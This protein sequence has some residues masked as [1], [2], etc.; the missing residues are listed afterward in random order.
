[1]PTSEPAPAASRVVTAVSDLGEALAGTSRL[2]AVLTRVLA[3]VRDLWQ[4]DRVLAAARPASQDGLIVERA[5]WPSTADATGLAA[6]LEH[7]APVTCRAPLTDQ[8]DSSAHELLA[9]PIL[10]TTRSIGVLAVGRDAGPFTADDQAALRAIASQA[11]IAIT[12]A[13]LLTRLAGGKRQWEQTVDAIPYAFCLVDPRGTILRANRAFANMVDCPVT[14]IPAHPWYAIMPADWRE[15][16]SLALATPD[17]DTPVELKADDRQYAATAVTMRGAE[18]GTVVLV[19]E[20]HTDKRTLQEQVVQA[21]K[22]SAI[23]QLIAGI[24]HE[25]NNPLASVV[26]FAEYLVEDRRDIP[27]HFLEPL[28][29]IH[30]EAERA[31]KIVRNLLAFARKQEGDRRP[32]AISSVLESTLMLL[33]NQLIAAKVEA[34]LSVAEDL[35]PLDANASQL[36]QVFVNL[37][38]NAAQAASRPP[39]GGH[40]HIVAES[41]LDGVAVTVVDDGPG[42]PSDIAD[43]VFEPFFTTK[44]EHEGTGLGL[45]ICHG[46]VTEHGG[47]IHLVDPSGPGAAF[48]VE[49]PGGAGVTL[50]SD[51]DVPESPSLRVLLI[52]DEPHILHYMRAALE[53][54]GHH[55]EVAPDGQAGYDVATERPFDVIITDLRMPR[56][57]GRDFYRTLRDNHPLIAER[58]VFCTGDTV[59]AATLDFLD[60]TGRPYLEKPFSLAELRSVLA[61]IWHPPTSQPMT[62]VE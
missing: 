40:I 25:L 15:P 30:Q 24:A 50:A 49:L 62:E 34:E 51:V 6:W 27:A 44:P 39:D 4:A 46:I 23:G 56:V 58:V 32:L 53:A 7:R 18:P 60:T 52:D 47:T 48:R 35:P 41:W 1:M 45:S 13:D 21:A 2:D 3:T 37:I 14:A 17:R 33:K 11:A 5:G 42:I 61:T 57:G 29:A 20:D 55:V 9:V 19:I 31:S 12:N 43:R 10:A 28:R 22:M 38:T 59:D 8:D 36:Q 16:V 54:W 26:G